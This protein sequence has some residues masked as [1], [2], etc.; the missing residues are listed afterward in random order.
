MPLRLGGE[1]AVERMERGSPMSS[2]FTFNTMVLNGASLEE[3]EANKVWVVSFCQ[4]WSW[5]CCCSGGCCS[6]G[7]RVR[8]QGRQGGHLPAYP[9]SCGLG[10]LGPRSVSWRGDNSS[11]W[12]RD[13]PCL[14]LFQKVL[15]IR[16]LIKKTSH[17]KGLTKFLAHV[18]TFLGKVN[19]MKIP[20]GCRCIFSPA[21]KKTGRR[22][23]SLH[24]NK[25]NT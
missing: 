2:N 11:P 8:L 21:H 14:A 20:S 25:H 6:G 23:T 10:F 9:G 12:T 7:C 13:Q 16:V 1:R 15:K 17:L 24:K 19:K 4:C 18:K 3:E 22:L 5:R